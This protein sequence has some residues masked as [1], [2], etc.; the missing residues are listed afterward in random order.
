MIKI[1]SKKENIFKDNIAFVE[2]WDFSKANLDEKNRVLAITQVAS[3]CYQ[4]P[5]A[6]GSEN[7]YN[8]LMSESMGLPS[9]SFEF[10]PI[11]LD[12]EKKE[13]QE[14]LKPE[15]SNVRKYCEIVE[16]GRYLL[17]N[18]RA[19]IYDYEKNPTLYSNDIRKIFN[20]KEECE[21]IKRNFYVFLFKVDL[22]TRSQMVR[23]RVSW[24]E[25][26]RRYVSAKRVPFEFYISENMK[27]I[28]SDL[29]KTEEIIKICLKH[30]F[31][32][33]E[34]GVKPQDARR[35]IPQ[36][37]YT[38]IWGAFMPNQL[39]NFFKLRLDSHAQREIREVAKAMKELI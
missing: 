3:I 18:Y 37:A 9:S 23:H 34:N 12:F 7:L 38:Q 16:N 14:I 8:R 26:S 13:H 17:T 25:L 22:P 27:D 5:K 28:Q 39:E 15:F 10:V 2:R 36:G 4:S 35:I 30:Y 11:L 20:T 31:K 19:V 29:G 24:Q 33:L 32:A 1:I 21:I 6:L